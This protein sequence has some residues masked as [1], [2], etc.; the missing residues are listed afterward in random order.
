MTDPMWADLPMVSFDLETTGVDVEQDRIVT[1]SIVRVTPGGERSVAE[2]LVDPGID[3]PQEATDVHGIT[4]EQ[5][6][7][8][9]VPTVECLPALVESLAAYASVGEPLV[10]YNA[11]YDL[12]LLDRECRRNGV[13]TLHQQMGDKPL[14]VIDPL[15][16]DRRLDPYRRGTGVRRLTHLCQ[17]VYN[18]PLSDEDAHGSTADALAAVR[19]AWKIAKTFPTVGYRP[20]HDLQHAQA[21][22]HRA[23]ADNFGA[24][25]ARQ[26]QPDDVERDWPI[27]P[28]FDR[29]KVRVCPR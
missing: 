5:A 8:E 4:T 3:I 9:G 10:V 2:W 12:T 1:A 22:W 13:P 23:W 29:D 16:L 7:A 26:G 15:V 24:Y 19:V 20:L 17:D 18:V 21:M 6:R 14:M 27:R 25:L 11:P 28:W